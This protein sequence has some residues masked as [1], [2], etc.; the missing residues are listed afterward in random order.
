M[1]K[2]PHRSEVELEAGFHEITRSP[3]DS[4]RVDMIV[5]RPAV[6]CREELEAAELDAALGL[7][8]DN[9]KAKGSKR[10]PDGSASPELQLTLM[11]SR[12]IALLAP[13]RCHWPLAGDQ[14]YIDFNLSLQNVPPGT[15]LAVGSAV[16]EI[17][18]P[19]HTG[20][21]KFQERFGAEAVKFVNSPRGRELQLRGVNARI[22]QSGSVRLGDAV[23]KLP[24]LA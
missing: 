10:T 7:L 1:D 2:P 18:P 21:R 5:R 15:R 20:C 6:D 22:V 16:I 3:L 9:W 19:P 11:N 4:G 12:V 23:A 24:A 8:G 13:E 17:T 14:L